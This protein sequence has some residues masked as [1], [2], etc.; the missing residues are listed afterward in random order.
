MLG[1]MRGMVR[2]DKVSP[3]EGTDRR[4]VHRDLTERGGEGVCRGHGDAG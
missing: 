4:D 3:L 2:V 1:L